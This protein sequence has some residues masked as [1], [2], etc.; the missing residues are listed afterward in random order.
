MDSLVVFG[1]IAGAVALLL[2]G[3]G[4]VRDGATEAFGVRL[5]MA[6]GLGTRTGPR[7]F[8]SGLV[9]TLGLQSSTATALMA[10]NFVDRGMMKERMAQ[11]ALLGANVGTALTAVIVSAGL[12]A[13][14]PALILLG[15]VMSRRQAARW[16]GLGRALIGLGLMLVSLTMLAQA[17]EVLRNAPQLAAFL[18]MLDA[19]WPVAL[20]FTA[21]LALACSSSLAAVLLIMSLNL[22]AGLTVV[23]VLGANLGGAIPAVLATAGLNTSARRV[24]LG[25][26]VV[27]SLGCLAVM[28]FAGLAGESLSQIPFPRTGL[29]VEAHLAFNIILALAI[30]PLTG[31]ISRLVSTILPDDEEHGASGPSLLDEAALETPP[32]ALTGASREVMAIGDSVDQM[33]TLT[34]R[35]FHDSDTAPLALVDELERRVDLRQQQVKTYLSRLGSATTEEERRQSI[36][37]LDYVINLEHVGDIISRG[38]AI[39]TRKKIGLSLRFSDEGYQEIDR[40]FL[41]TQETMRLAQSVFMSRDRDMAR[42]LMEMKVDVRKLERQSAQRHLIRLREGN[43][44]TRE[45]SSLHLDILRDLKRINAHVVSVAHPILDE[46]GLLFESRLRSN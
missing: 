19:A 32:L 26:L 2:F 6:L 18:P 45:T 37:I 14:A 10:A 29:A 25:N 31:L 34:R 5:R 38:L 40:M 15:Y 8:L 28:P 41:M 22:P 27:R 17:T 21:L 39:E 11:I 4:L 13:A 9:A 36:T 3:I 1:Q 35:A 44:Q 33:L 12:E 46:E 42:R 20:V 16:S 24:T 30:W 43:E 7:A 23:M